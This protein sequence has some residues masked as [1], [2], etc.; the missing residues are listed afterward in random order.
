MP[1]WLINIFGAREI[2]DLFL[3]LTIGP[4]PVWIGLVVFPNEKWT[5]MISSPF[6]VPPLMSLAYVFLLW[7][8]WEL[9]GPAAPETMVKSVRGFIEHPLIFLVLWAHLQMANLFVGMVLLQDA[10]RNGLS[11]RVELALCWIFAPV[12]VL[13][14]TIRRFI[15][16]KT[17]F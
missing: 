10:R 11:V 14:Y 7:K 12:G 6:V 2:N 4:L 3:L 9:G 13:I 16:Q 17:F 1:A 8:T 5:R 15:R